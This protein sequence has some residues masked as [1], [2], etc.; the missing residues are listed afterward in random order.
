MIDSGITVQ[1]QYEVSFQVLPTNFYN[2]CHNVIHFSTGSDQGHSGSRIPLV[3]FCGSSGAYTLYICSEVNGDF[4]YCVNSDQKPLNK[5]TSVMIRQFLAN[6]GSYLYEV[7]VDRKTILSVINNQVKTFNQV[8]VYVSDPWV[9]AQ[10][11]RMKD[12]YYGGKYCTI[13]KF[14]NNILFSYILCCIVLYKCLIF[15][16]GHLFPPFCT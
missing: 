15:I 12:L 14:Q 7:I 10:D 1:Q 4:D 8:N 11:G 13:S 6:G 9:A 5:W 3:S 2:F 16:G